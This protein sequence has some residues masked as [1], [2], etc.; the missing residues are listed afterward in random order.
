MAQVHDREKE[1]YRE[2]GQTVESGLAGVEVLAVE[3]SGPDRFTV[4]IDHPSGVDHRLCA[5]VTDLL[6]P[7]LREYAVDVSS[8]GIERPLRKAAHFSRAEGRRIALRT[9]GEISGRTR[10]RGELLAADE[11]RVTVSTGTAGQVHIP[12]EQ[13]VRAN[14]I[15]EG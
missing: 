7:Y 5:R 12:Y 3:L 13:I 2:V 6:R 14:L 9:A 8:P 1:L 10:F 11:L 15:D 4:Y